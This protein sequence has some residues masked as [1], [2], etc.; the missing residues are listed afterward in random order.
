MTKHLLLTA[1]AFPPARTSGVHRAAGIAHAFVKEGWDVTVLTAPRD[2]FASQTMIDESLLGSVDRQVSIVEIPFV[3]SVYDTDVASWTRTRARQ[4][5]LWNGLRLAHERRLFPE[6]GFGLWR[7]ALERAAE[8]IHQVQPV[9]LAIGTAN[10]YVDFVPGRLLHRRFGVPAVMDY[11]DAWTIDVFTGR[12]SASATRGEHEWEAKLMS[13]AARIWFVNEPIQGWHA[14]RHPQESGRMRVVPNGFDLVG[15][16]SPAVD[17]HPV[18]PDQGVTFGYIGTINFG[19]FPADA[20]FAGWELA[21]EMDELIARSRLVLRGH[22]GRTGVASP[23]LK[24][25]L[26]D[27]ARHDVSYGGPVAK[28]DLVTAYSEFDALA[29]ALASGPGVTSGKVFEYA[30]TGLP[31]ASVHD[32]SSAASSILR[33]SPVWEPAKSLSADDVADAL[34]RT[35]RRAVSQTPEDRALAIAWG[36]QWERGAQLSAAVRELT[37]LVDERTA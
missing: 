14:Q 3:S 24:S 34:I 7:P 21:R 31:I 11:R 13:E 30:A 19:Q 5:E 16:R 22:L 8:R 36:S 9:D 20:L 1:W 28:A 32:P 15:G 37:E 10:P 18:D 6:P 17:Y 35:G 25:L 23:Q 26:T 2:T 4:P 12:E 29:L 33:D 27:A